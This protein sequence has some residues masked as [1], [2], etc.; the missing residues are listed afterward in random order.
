MSIL[1]V[2]ELV[3]DILVRSVDGIDF[4]IDSMSVDEISLKSGGDA[5]NVS[6]NLARLGNKVGFSGKIGRDFL[7]KFLKGAAA[8]RKVDLRNL[9]VCDEI[10]T[11]AVIALIREDG[12]RTFLHFNGSNDSFCISDIDLSLLK[13]YTFLHIGGTF[14][15]PAFDGEGTLQL[16]KAAKGMGLIT[17]MDVAWDRSGQWL[18]KIGR[19]LPSIDYFIPSDNEARMLTGTD[20][21]REMAFRLKAAGVK[22]VVIKMGDKGAYGDIQ[23]KQFFCNTHRVKVVDTTGA[24]DGFVSGFLTGLAKG[25]DPV[26][27]VK[28]GTT[29]A[30]FIIQKVGATEGSPTFQEITHF[31]STETELEI[32]HV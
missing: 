30:S 26:S 27:C 8:E 15:L 13:K 25:A 16:L 17:S 9:C 5:F 12:A 29:V 14:H 4:T 6:L 24:G 7:G 28:Y 11:S 32:L 21:V 18:K 20:D 3:A 2:G 19:C 31:L 10:P 22:N 1:C 23:G